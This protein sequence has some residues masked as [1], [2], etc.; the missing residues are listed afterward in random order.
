M[1]GWS[2]RMPPVL[3]NSSGFAPAGPFGSGVS[4][5]GM[6]IAIIEFGRGLG[7]PSFF[8]ARPRVLHA[9]RHLD[10][11]TREVPWEIRVS[12]ARGR[13]GGATLRL[14]EHA[15]ARELSAPGLPK[16]PLMLSSVAKV[17]TVFGDA[18]TIS[19]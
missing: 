6:H 16:P 18:N 14:G 9:N 11:V 1:P 5:N 17:A 4:E 13:L 15:Y 3:E 7:A 2:G 19:S 10:D 12:G 8:T